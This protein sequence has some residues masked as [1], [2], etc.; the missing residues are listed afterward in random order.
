MLR[1][2]YAGH[3]TAVH[4]D[5]TEARVFLVTQKVFDPNHTAKRIFEFYQR[6]RI[7]SQS[8]PA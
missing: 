4:R 2:V 3:R 6:V 7:H 1:E 5:G 8:P